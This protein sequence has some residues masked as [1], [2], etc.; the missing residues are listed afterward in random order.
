MKTINKTIRY[1][2]ALLPFL[3][4]GCDSEIEKATS[5]DQPTE[6]GFLCKGNDFSL[7]QTRATNLIGENGGE[8][9]GTFYILQTKAN[10]D[11]DDFVQWG[12][13]KWKNG[14]D[15]DLEALDGTRKL[16]W[17]DGNTEYYFRGITVPQNLSDP[18]KPSGVTFLP[19]ENPTEAKGEV[20]FGGY[21][22]G[23]EY[24]VGVTIGPQKLANGQTITM[25]FKRQTCKVIFRKFIHQYGVNQNEN[26]EG[27]L[28]ITF[29]NLPQ[30]A[31]FDMT[32]FHKY[33]NATIELAA[34]SNFVTFTP[35]PEKGVEITLTKEVLKLNENAI[36]RAIYLMPFKFWGDD[37]DNRPEN[38]PGFFVVEYKGKKYTGNIYGINYPNEGN[39][40]E[41][42]N[43]LSNNDY[44]RLDIT[45][46]DGPV[47]GD[48]NGS[49][50]VD[51]NVAGEETTSHHRIPG[52]YT[53]E[54]ALSLLEALQGDEGDIPNTF[55]EE[56]DEGE[57]KKKIIR[58]FINI[59]WSAV[60]GKLTIPEGFVL[61]GQGY[62]IK[63]GAGGSIGGTV[64]GDLYINGKL[65]TTES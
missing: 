56:K 15:G 41:R 30:K 50:I 17:E 12:Y 9:F 20:T 18:P 40:T 8:K 47:E 6:V 60:N 27:E 1:I 23:L 33:D 10:A 26:V 35:L 45:L 42:K 59:D 64:N 19:N 51:W 53:Q 5:E 36:E 28:H 34:E 48:G 63:M 46:Q 7:V 43:R 58:L 52:I 11:K 39:P 54:D 55:Y 16:Y 13:Y 31:T 38:Q 65:S 61:M 14:T 57:E 24:F 44:C 29:P 3:W 32:S 22:T 25:E 37:S 2:I 49:I 21:K 62:N 4:I